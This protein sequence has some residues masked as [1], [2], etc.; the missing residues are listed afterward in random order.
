[1]IVRSSLHPF[2]VACALASLV[3][4]GG[5][6]GAAPLDSGAIAFDMTATLHSGEERHVCQFVRMPETAT[7]V[8]GGSYET[9][10]GTHHFLLFRTSAI[11]DSPPVIGVPVDCFE[12]AGVMRFERGFV[13]G[14]QLDHDAAH[15][16]AGVALAFAPGE[17]LL[18]QG[19]FLNTT[20]GDA[21][22]K[23]HVELDPTPATDVLHRVGTY[24]FYDPY[25][26]VPPHGQSTARMRCPIRHDVTLLSVGSHMHE[27]GVAYRA[28]FD[29]SEG[30]P[31]ATPFFTTNDWQ[32]PPYWYGPMEAK[33]G[34]ALRFE[35]DYASKE[36]HSIAQGLRAREDEMCM[37]SAFYFPESPG[38][39]DC[40]SGDMHGT[41]TRSCAQTNSCI[42][43]CSPADAPRF[44]EG[45]A[46]VGTCWQQCIVDSCPNVTA[47]LIPQQLC[48]EAHCADACT[49]YGAACTSCIETSCKAELDACQAL[50]CD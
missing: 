31:A 39:D 46:D 44:G 50:S 1:M 10:V 23:I 30:A 49:S 11:I 25:I 28:Y 34:S 41:G 37:L 8:R 4:C 47:K 21:V 15:F 29:A 42:A 20:A 5:T 22:S 33:A 35:C 2:A 48:T 38:D 9:T 36:D 45:R 16:P 3:S 18:F 17:I 40:A 43:L 32:H 7:F 14:G 27:R 6:K 19:H 12:G 13:S 24:R 26:V